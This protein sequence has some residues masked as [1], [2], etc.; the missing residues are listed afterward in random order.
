M[1]KLLVVAALC[2]VGFADTITYNYTG[3]AY[4]VCNGT[5]SINGSCPANSFIDHSVASLTFSAPLGA[6]LSNA[7]EVSSPNLVGWSI[8]DSLGN[9]PTFAST[10]PNAAAEITGT[11]V[12][13][14]QNGI[15]LS[16]NGSG[17]ITGW[18]M[19]ASNAEAGAGIFSPT[20]IGGSGFPIA[21]AIVGNVSDVFWHLSNGFTG[22]WTQTLNGFQGGAASAPVFLLG[23]SPVAGV[24]GSIGGLGA[25]E[26]YGFYWNGGAFSATAS[27][28]TTDGSYLFT[29]GS[30]GSFCSGGA[31]EALNNLDGF[32]NTIAIAN[33]APGQY[34]IGIENNS[35]ADPIFAFTFLTPVNGVVP[36]PSGLIPIFVALGLIVFLRRTKLRRS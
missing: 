15:S 32:T 21:D 22:T 19:E 11:G 6:N 13:N 33:L 12:A 16:T 17:A 1:V 8:G 23:G 4:T 7:N 10:D 35:A 29:E 36:E 30:T 26:Y 28:A 34:C 25:E 27:V 5:T 14:F 20:F 18:T 24:S 3:N 31:S 2:T 9:N